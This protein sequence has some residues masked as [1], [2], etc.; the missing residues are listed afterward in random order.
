MILSICDT[1][2][3]LKVMRLVNIIITIIRIAIP[4]LL[5]VSVMIDYMN[6]IKDN[7]ELSKTSKLAVTKLTAAI[8]VFL[9][10]TFVSIIAGVVNSGEYKK[11]I[12]NITLVQIKTAYIDKEEELVSKAEQT[13]N[14]N[15]Y[16]NA[17]NYLVNLS[18]DKK[19]EYEKRLK[20]IKDEL[21]ASK[22]NNS[23]NNGQNAYAKVNYS[24]FKWNLYYSG[25]GP[26]NK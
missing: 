1:P 8:L 4:I 23:N 25:K 14:L 17:L 19:S 10:P 22:N 18:G 21:D 15:D 20:A 24:K 11:C 16:N 2:E 9:I 7:D 6:A 13:K 26:A 5:I 3:V 12:G